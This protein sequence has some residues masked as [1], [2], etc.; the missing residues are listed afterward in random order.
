MSPQGRNPLL[1][2]SDVLPEL[3]GQRNNGVSFVALARQLS[4]RFN[5]PVSAVSV[6]Q[7]LTAATT[8][9]P[10]SA[11]AG[12]LPARDRATHD[13]LLIAAYVARTHRADPAELAQETGLTPARVRALLPR[14]KRL[15]GGYV[16]PAPLPARPK[17]GDH[18]LARA[19]HQAAATLGTGEHVSLAGYNLWRGSLPAPQRAHTPTT[20]V[21]QRRYGSWTVALTAA[22]LHPVAVTHPFNG[23]RPDDII[24]WVACWLRE[25]AT[26]SPHIV[27]ATAGAYTRWARNIDGAPSGELTRMHY[28]WIPLVHAASGRE[29]SVRHLPTPRPAGAKVARRTKPPQV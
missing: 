17:Y 1:P 28:S 25:L 26:T 5:R 29:R 27:R 21:F 12:R 6:R 3:I 20:R 7:H 2:W 8:P 9:H 16:L 4:E 10:A 14:A 24:N 18:E 19:L 23:L 15:T 13:A 11:G 22:G